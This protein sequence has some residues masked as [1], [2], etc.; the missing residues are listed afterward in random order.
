[1]RYQL[2]TSL[3]IQGM[4]KGQK[5]EAIQD[6]NLLYTFKLGGGVQGRKVKK[7]DIVTFLNSE[8][9]F[10]TRIVNCYELLYSMTLD[11]FKKNFI[12]R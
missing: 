4:T 5:F 12:T 3:N 9:S 8:V 6:T 7:G 2:I 10:S 1:L 11:E